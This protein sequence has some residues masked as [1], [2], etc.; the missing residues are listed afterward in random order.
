MM[1]ATRVSR[2]SLSFLSPRFDVRT[3]KNTVQVILTDDLT[4]VGSKGE[5]L[6]V[7]KGFARNFLFPK[8]LAVYA[9]DDSRVQFEEFAAMVDPEARQRKKK[10]NRIRSRLSKIKLKLK[11]HNI[12]DNCLHSNITSEILSEKLFKQTDILIAPEHFLLERD[13]DAFGQHKVEVVVD[14]MTVDLEVQ[15][16]ER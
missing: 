11:R 1:L 16:A 9:T 8:Q 15:V 13:L 12:G 3:I 5:E 14:N 6:A 4:G 10:I 7:K 2:R